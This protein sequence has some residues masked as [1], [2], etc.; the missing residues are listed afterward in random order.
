MIPSNSK[1]LKQI[2]IQHHIFY[3]KDDNKRYFCTDTKVDY[4]LVV[5]GVFYIPMVIENRLPENWQNKKL[6]HFLPMNKLHRIERIESDTLSGDYHPASDLSYAYTM[7][8]LTPDSMDERITESLKQLRQAVGNVQ[9]FVAERLNYSLFEL[10]QVLSNEQI[11]GV[12]LAIYNAEAR[13]QGVIIGDQT[14]VGKGRMAAAFLRY[15][16]EK[17]K[18]PI[19]FTKTAE[20]FPDI[21]RDL[22]AIHCNYKLFT[23]N[24]QDSAGKKLQILDDDNT[25]LL[26]YDDKLYKKAKKENRIPQEC[27]VMLCTYTQIVEKS[28]EKVM[29]IEQVAKGNILVLDEAHEAGGDITISYTRKDEDG[30]I[31]LSEPKIKGFRAHSFLNN[32]IPNCESVVYLSATF[33]KRP[34]NMPLYAIKTCFIDAFPDAKNMTS[35][36]IQDVFRYGGN[37][38]EEIASSTLVEYGQ[39]LRRERDNSKVDINFIKLDEEN[40]Q[41]YPGIKDEV[42]RHKVLF[43]NVLSIIKKL[44][45]FEI[46]YINP[47]VNYLNEKIFGESDDYTAEQR[48]NRSPKWKDKDGNIDKV[49][50]QECEAKRTTQLKRRLPDIMDVVM[51][52][53]KAEAVGDRAVYYLENGCKPVIGF[54]STLDC[55]MPTP[56][57]KSKAKDGKS[58]K[59]DDDTEDLMSFNSEFDADLMRKFKKILFNFRRIKVFHHEKSRQI[60]RNEKRNVEVITDDVVDWDLFDQWADEDEDFAEEKKPSVFYN[61]L[62]DI[63]ENSKLGIPISPIDVIRKKIEDAGYS[64]AECTGRT[65]QIDY[66]DKSFAKGIFKEREKK[67]TSQCYN[68][69]ND[70]VVDCL[71]INATGSTGKSAHAIPTK[72]V[73]ASKVKRRVLIIAQAEPDINNEIQKRGR[74]NRT[75][76]L[77]HIPPIIEYIFSS[78]PSERKLMMRLKKK[79]RSLTANTSANQDAESDSMAESDIYN[80]FGDE[81]AFSLFKNNWHSPYKMVYENVLM[82]NPLKVHWNQKKHMYV[83]GASASNFAQ[84]AFSTIQMLPL[85]QQEEFYSEFDFWYAKAIQRAKE[86][87]DY[88]LEAEDRDYQGVVINEYCLRQGD[89]NK[90]RFGSSTFMTHLSIKSQKKLPKSA[91]LNNGISDDSEKILEYIKTCYEKEQQDHKDSILATKPDKIDRLNNTIASLNEKLIVLK[92]RATAIMTDETIIDFKDALKPIQ[93]KIAET[94]TKIEEAQNSLKNIDAELQ[95]TIDERLEAVKKQYVEITSI[96]KALKVGSVYRDKYGDLMMVSSLTANYINDIKDPKQI[97]QSVNYFTRQSDIFVEFVTTNGDIEGGIRTNLADTDEKRAEISKIINQEKVS[98]ADWDSFISSNSFR[99]NVYI[100]T[101]NV[102]PYI[103]HALKGAIVHYTMQDGSS[104]IGFQVKLERDEKTNRLKLPVIVN[105]VSLIIDKFKN[106]IKKGLAGGGRIEFIHSSEKFGYGDCYIDPRRISDETLMYTL[107]FQKRHKGVFGWLENTTYNDGLYSYTCTYDGLQSLLTRMHEHGFN[108][109]IPFHLI[110]QY[111]IELG[112]EK[113]QMQDWKPLSYDKN[114]IP[115]QPKNY[116]HKLFVKL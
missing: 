78:L 40:A 12:A 80:V 100:I 101:G 64:I 60:Y 36:R 76:Q 89:N 49:M 11:D 17:G 98:I 90:S 6:W 111:G 10:S 59:S 39:M 106:E 8:L 33:A 15:A 3:L 72:K 28:K 93:D 66:L 32:I 37:A 87:G 70:N 51:F 73:P 88:F 75:G 22:K 30:N 52:S 35:R 42:E 50:S 2:D 7:N 82:D 23:T 105:G 38:V 61:E 74:I 14:G 48:W 18:K 57:S 47:Y 31:D 102:I 1:Q 69:F 56:I 45:Y 99:E 9:E 46:Y 41:K 81:V 20:L 29:F 24:A 63:I 109:K 25:L 68:D 95:Q 21:I 104:E 77:E 62:M 94:Q 103:C 85:N 55:I 4:S 108:A 27:D 43:N 112:G 113:Y 79:L 19:F 13:N 84:T 86:N 71:F 115:K 44:R 58:D 16:V 83:V 96:I 65:T 97:Y 92:E 114:K 26:E 5:R 91:E 110:D 67:S 54:S 34:D 116:L 107:V 53:L